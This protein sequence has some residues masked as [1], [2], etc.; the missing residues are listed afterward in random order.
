MFAAPV[1]GGVRS[2][3][4]V[5]VS[6][7]CVS[8]ETVRFGAV[9]VRNVASG[10]SCRI[11]APSGSSPYLGSHMARIVLKRLAQ[12]LLIVWLTTTITFFLI[13]AAPGEPF[14]DM[15]TDPRASA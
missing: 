10:D 13:H 9:T 15:L 6:S 1:M 2:I 3:L 5:P 12:G 11:V 8:P 14:A 4:H 7:D